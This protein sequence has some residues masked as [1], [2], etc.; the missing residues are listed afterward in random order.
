MFF[1]LVDSS[2]FEICIGK[3]EFSVYEIKM[4]KSCLHWEMKLF[5]FLNYQNS[6]HKNIVLIISEEDYNSAESQYNGHN[7]CESLRE[8]EP[9]V[10]VHS[11][12]LENLQSIQEDNY[13]KSWNILSKEKNAWEK[14]P[15]GKL[16]NDPEDLKDYVMLGD[17]NSFAGEIV[18][19]S[20][21]KEQIIC[22]PNELYQ[23][24][25]RLYFD[26]EKIAND[27]LLIRDGIHYKVKNFLPFT[28]YLLC[29]VT[30]SDIKVESE[31]TPKEFVVKANAYFKSINQ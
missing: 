5:D 17:I 13:L 10:L 3:N 15:I 8:Y 22:D 28:N 2:E 7:H 12:T 1:H 20:K 29:C 30:A 21:Q 19:M 11:T 18:V 16:L 26:L 25:V 4:S 24:G 31:I 9:K 23:P 27:G 14:E 6:Y